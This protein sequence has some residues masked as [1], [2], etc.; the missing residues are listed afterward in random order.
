MS[1]K[2]YDEYDA[3]GL[4]ELVYGNIFKV[5]PYTMAYNLKIVD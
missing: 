5:K 3:I 1:F 4:A 2:E